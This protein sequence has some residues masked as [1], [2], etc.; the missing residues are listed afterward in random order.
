VV[1]AQDPA[2]A[3]QGVPIQVAGGTHLAQGAQVGGQVMRGGQGGGMVPAQDLA[4]AVQGVLVQVAGRPDLAQL[5][6]V[7][8]QVIHGE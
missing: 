4:Q 2:A 1:L 8:G 7:K 3:V 6:Q 5:A